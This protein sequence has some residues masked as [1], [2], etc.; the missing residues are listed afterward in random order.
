V[1]WWIAG[2]WALDLFLGTQSR[3][4]EDLDIGILRRDAAIATAEL[5]SWDVFEMERGVLST[6]HLGA[7][8]RGSVNSLWCRPEGTSLWTF[9]FLLEA[10]AD[11]DW[12]YRRDP[13][14]RRSLT[15]LIRTHPSGLRYIAPE[16]QLLFKAR[17]LR[18]KD[19]VDF[20]RIMPVL[21]HAAREWLHDRLARTEPQCPWLSTLGA[22]IAR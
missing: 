13:T 18:P 1:P 17:H 12:V 7:V 5:R 6:L 19:Q 14:V 22:G 16:V 15:T 21:D 4:H 20:E 9:E 8:P 3:A 10:S 11:D 2:G